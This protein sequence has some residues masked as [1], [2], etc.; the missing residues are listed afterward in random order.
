MRVTAIVA[1]LLAS[2]GRAI[3]HSQSDHALIRQ[4]K[5]ACDSPV[6]L[7]ASTN[8]WKE[9]KLNPNILYRRKVEAAAEVINNVNLKEK[10][11]KVADAGT[12]TWM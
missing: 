3:P 4:A 9:Y 5:G 10:A 8:I 6:S 1:G 2:V 12:F 7:N 11:Q